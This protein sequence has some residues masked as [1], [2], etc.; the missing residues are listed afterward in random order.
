MQHRQGN[1]HLAR[2]RAARDVDLLYGIEAVA[3]HHDVLTVPERIPGSPQADHPELLSGGPTALYEGDHLIFG[4]RGENL[5]PTEVGM[6]RPVREADTLPFDRL[7]VW[8][9]PLHGTE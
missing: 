9:P 5:G 4:F 8:H 3:R 7:H 2:D 6:P 1:P